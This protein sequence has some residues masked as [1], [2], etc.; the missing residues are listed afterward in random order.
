M[1][2]N[3]TTTSLVFLF[4]LIGINTSTQ[5]QFWKKL[6]KKV[7]KKIEQ[8]VEKKIDKETDKTI[9]NALEGNKE[10]TETAKKKTQQQNTTIKNFKSKGIASINHSNEF[11]MVNINKID[12]VTVTK[13][14]NTYRIYGNWITTGIDVFDGFSIELKNVENT[15][16]L[17]SKTFKIP[18]EATLH[19]GYE[20]QPKGS[21]EGESSGKGQSYDLKSGSISVNFQKDKNFSFNFNGNADLTVG[22]RKVK[23]QDYEEPIKQNAQV[24]GNGNINNP[25]FKIEKSFNTSNKTKNKEISDA[26]IEKMM[27]KASPT[28]NIPSSFSFNKNIE[29]EI[30]DN[31]GKKFPIEFLLGKYPDIYGMLVATKEMKGQGNVTMVITPKSSTMFMNIAGMKMKKTTSLD[32][33]GQ[34]FKGSQNIPDASD[35]SYKK[36]GTTKTILG[37]TCHEYKVTYNHEGNKGTSSLWISKK[38]PIQNKE[39]PML[40]MKMNNPHF[41]G[42]VLEINS[43]YQ[44]ENYNIKVTN[45]SNKNVTINTKDYRN[46]GF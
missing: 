32:Q 46:M 14:G 5:A 11:G 44:G 38:F 31:A 33:I 23:N 15:K 16:Q 37:Y 39:L 41:S 29:L 9:D 34:Q 13:Q 10:K 24:S 6:T 45:I 26:E 21:Y 30:T 25:I 42:F 43:I 12:N 27:Q 35:Y 20:S 28:V 17:N 19:L 36:T 4:F 3:K 7:Q 22:Y 1:K 18:E 8:K 40:G 2:T